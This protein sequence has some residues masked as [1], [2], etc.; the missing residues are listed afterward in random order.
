MKSFYAKGN[1]HIKTKVKFAQLLHGSE[2]EGVETTVKANDP[3]LV[4]IKAIMNNPNMPVYF[5]IPGV[6]TKDLRRRSK[7]HIDNW[8][9]LLKMFDIPKLTYPFELMGAKK[10]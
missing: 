8:E 4:K 2:I 10:I 5:E 9:H 3:D 7:V 1:D 6:C